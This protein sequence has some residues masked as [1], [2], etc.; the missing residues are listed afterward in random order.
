M[1]GYKSGL[2]SI[3]DVLEAQSQLQEARTKLVES[4]K[5]LFVSSADLAR[6]MGTISVKDLG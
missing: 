6:A 2:K 4:Q 3:L 1:E 5:D